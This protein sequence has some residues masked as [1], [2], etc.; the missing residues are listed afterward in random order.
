MFLTLGGLHIPTGSNILIGEVGE[1]DD[2]ALLCITDLTMCCRSDDT[3]GGSSLGEWRYPDGSFVPISDSGQSFYRDRGTGIVRL[4]QRN[5]TMSPTGQ[6]CCEVP[7]A[8]FTNVITCINIGEQIIIT[9]LD[10]K[11]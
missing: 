5:A 8:T 2:G 11:I 4:N 10:P 9:D 7:D 1:G 6:F 3:G